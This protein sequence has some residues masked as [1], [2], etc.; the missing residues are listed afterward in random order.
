MLWR[1]IIPLPYDSHP[2][3]T[4]EASGMHGQNCEGGEIEAGSKI[5]RKFAE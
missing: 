4:R 5:P 1:E 3:S 2:H